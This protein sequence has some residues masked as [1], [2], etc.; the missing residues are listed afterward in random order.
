MNPGGHDAARVKRGRRRHHWG[1]TMDGTELQGTRL[2]FERRRPGDGYRHVLRKSD[3]ERFIALL[4]EWDRL[5]DDLTGVVLLPGNPNYE[6]EYF[7]TWIGICAWVRDLWEYY[8]ASYLLHP[9]QSIARLGVPIE[10]TSVGIVLKWTETTVR[11]YQLL[12]VFLHELGHHE[13]RMATRRKESGGRGEPFA[14]AYADRYAREIWSNYC[15]EFGLVV[16]P[17]SFEE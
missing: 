7:T 11:A 12:D 10:R 3:L 1:R 14:E 8:D 6:G 15:D 16:D 2:H 4:P 5:A 13:D 17:V 9:R